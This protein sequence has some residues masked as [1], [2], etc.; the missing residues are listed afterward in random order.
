MT[1]IGFCLYKKLSSSVPLLDFRPYTVN[2]K[3]LVLII[4]DNG[5]KSF[6]NVTVYSLTYIL[7]ITLLWGFVK[8]VFIDTSYIR[9]YRIIPC[10]NK[11]TNTNIR[12]KTYKIQ[13]ILINEVI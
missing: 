7:V 8:Q 12:H 13:V 6:T 1:G 3:D 10:N 9:Y 2:S 11:I 5:K 4:Y